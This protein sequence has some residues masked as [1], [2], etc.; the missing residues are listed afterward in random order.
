MAL[1]TYAVYRER[2]SVKLAR[3][4]ADSLINSGWYKR[5]SSKSRKRHGS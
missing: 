2:R 5:Y 4:L 1:F 3:E